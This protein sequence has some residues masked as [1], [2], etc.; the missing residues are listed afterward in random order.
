MHHNVTL[1]QQ[2]GIDQSIFS[3]GNREAAPFAEVNLRA[4]S[5]RALDILPDDQQGIVFRK[6]P[7]ASASSVAR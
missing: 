4:I 2:H 5:G 3:V 1:G 7:A 6:T